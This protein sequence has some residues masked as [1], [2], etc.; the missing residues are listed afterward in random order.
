VQCFELSKKSP[1]TDFLSAACDTAFLFVKAAKT[2][3]AAAG[4]TDEGSESDGTWGLGGPA[5]DRLLLAISEQSVSYLSKAGSKLSLLPLQTLLQR[6]TDGSR[7][8]GAPTA[9]GDD[10]ASGS[11][12]DIAFAW[13]LAP[14]LASG[15]LEG[16][17]D[18]R[19]EE[20]FK[21]SY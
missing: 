17:N 10:N 7:K 20:C 14:V 9:G 16:R 12:Q 6:A 5:A 21:L 4:Q 1:G 18:F 8:A 11:A 19:R 2:A 15:C 3:A 13:R